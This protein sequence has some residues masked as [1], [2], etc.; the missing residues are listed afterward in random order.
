MVI[1]EP[2]RQSDVAALT[3]VVARLR[4]ALRSSIRT[5][6]PYESLPIAQVEL[7]QAL[8]EV[9]SL[10]IGDLASQLRLAANTVSGLASQLID[11]GLVDRQADPADRRAGLLTLTAAGRQKLSDWQAAHERRIGAALA[12]LAEQ[13][14]AAITA[15][16][17]ALARLVATL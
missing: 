8:G 10:R 16:I 4:R 15:A 13:D 1:S 2:A 3:D 5:D 12:T 11:A 9:P 14:R 6:Y 17:P 7:M